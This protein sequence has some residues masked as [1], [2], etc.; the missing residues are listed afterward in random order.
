MCGIIGYLGKRK[1][2]TILLEGLKRLEYRGY[3]SA[4]VAIFDGSSIS[5]RRVKGKLVN[6]ENSLNESPLDGFYG[7]GHTRWA[8]H[9]RPSEENAHPHRDCSGSIV[10]VHN[11][12]IENYLKLKEELS[13]EGHKFNSETDSEVI[14]HLIEKYF[15]GSLLS[16]LRRAIQRLEGVFSILAISKEEP[17]KIV[18]G[19]MGPPLILGIGKEEFLLSSDLTAIIPYTKDVVF[20]EDAEVLEVSTEGFSFFDFQGRSL[21]KERKIINWDPIMIEKSGFKHFMLKEIHEQPR[22]LRETLIGRIS[23]ENSKVYIDEMNLSTEFLSKIERIFIIACG[24]SWHAGLIGK[25]LLEKIA[26]VQCEVDYASEFRYR[27]FLWNEKT[28]GLSI[29]QSG[30]T[31]D[32]LAGMREIK[33]MGGK[34]I[35]IC[36]VEGSTASREADGTILTHAGPEIGVAS[37]KAFTSQI[38]TLVL[39]AIYLGDIRRTISKEKILELLQE[40]QKIPQKLEIVL[41]NAS[42]IETLTTKFLSCTDFLYLGRWI[43]Y[44]VALEGALKLKEIAYVHAEGYPAGEMKH[45]PIA[46][47]DD[48]MPVFAIIPKDR[49]EAKVLS[50]ISEVK[51]RNGIVIAV[52]TEGNNEIEEK[53]DEVIYIPKT[54][55]LFTPFLTVVPLQLFAYYM[56]LKKGHDVDQPRN[57]AKSVTVE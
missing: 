46:L 26:K 41:K 22:A 32:T 5:I 20:V 17:F 1:V 44:P 13:K 25:Y 42:N 33:K 56:A 47:I 45:G 53:F 54:H 29:S 18:G 51:A 21:I 4:G 57:L 2:S 28:M 7:I 48:K 11:G 39:L 8:T 37:T 6:L 52:T 31:A 49:V 55:E 38:A 3:D 30:E 27:D 16:A 19:R 10:V 12:I 35:T 34:V 23:L 9:G 40:L 15:E 36:N 24:T 43:N 14:A 50:N